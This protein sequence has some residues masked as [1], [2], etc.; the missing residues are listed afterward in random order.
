MGLPVY[1]GARYLAEALESLLSQTFGD[2]ELLI[3]D[4]GS[5]DGTTEIAREIASRDARVRHLHSP[6]NR[7]AAWNYNRLFHESRGRYF[8]WA[9]HDDLCAPTY[10]ERVVAALEDATE[11]VVSAHSL[12]TLIDE[13]GDVTGDWDD[14]FSLANGDPASRVVDLVRH[15]VMSNVFFGL[16]RRERARPDAVA[17]RV[18]VCGLGAPRRARSPGPVRDRPRAPLLPPRASCDVPL[19]E[20]HAHRRCGLV[21]AG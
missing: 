1:N 16:T 11:D 19:R 7:G 3:G 2:F 4:N 13:H 15:I 17:R 6:E 10:L 14:E 8:R 9:A 18:P 5:T 20:P 21:R 12:T